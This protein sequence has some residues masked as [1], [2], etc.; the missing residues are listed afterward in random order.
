MSLWR[1]LWTA[2]IFAIPPTL[3]AANSGVIQVTSVRSWS[4]ADSTRVIIQTTGPFEFRSDR[5]AGPDR[6]Y[7]DIL[8]ARPWIA[9]RR[10]AARGDSGDRLVRQ[11][12]IAET[13]PGTTRHRVRAG[14]SGRFQRLYQGSMH[15]GT[16]G[17]RVSAR[18]K[19]VRVIY[20]KRVSRP[21]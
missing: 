5:A 1:L 17:H 20:A 19:P 12:R 18:N 6:L 7:V 8:H 11:V 9:K 21:P 14:E 13:S 2:A 10:F 15:A 4:H 3:A 16:H